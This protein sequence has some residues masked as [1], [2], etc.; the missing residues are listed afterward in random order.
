MRGSGKLRDECLNREI[1][2]TLTQTQI[3]IEQWRRFY[4]TEMPHSSPGY[5]HLHL[6]PYCRGGRQSHTLQP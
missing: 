4:N 6:K 2:T 3:L 5:R 1:F